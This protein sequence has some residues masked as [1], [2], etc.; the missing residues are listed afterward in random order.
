MSK[1]VTDV[2]WTFAE[3]SASGSIRVQNLFYYSTSINGNTWLLKERGETTGVT[4]LPTSDP[5]TPEE[6]ATL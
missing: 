5:E 3:P 4:F 6:G 1:P 2:R